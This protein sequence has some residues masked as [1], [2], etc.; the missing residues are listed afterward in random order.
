MRP[1][2]KVSSDDVLGVG[3]VTLRVNCAPDSDGFS[4]FSG[5][6]T[7]CGVIPCL[8]RVTPVNVVYASFTSEV[9]T[10]FYAFKKH[11]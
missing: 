11:P 3:T 1:V 2:L 10:S 7:P 9:A 6:N 5:M 4:S 8:R